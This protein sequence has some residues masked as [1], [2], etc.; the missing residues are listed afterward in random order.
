VLLSIVGLVGCGTTRSSDTKRTAT[1]QILISDAIDRAVVALK[2][3]RLSGH[4]IFFDDRYLYDAVD[5]GYLISSIRQ[6]LLANGCILKDERTDA[7]FVVE[8][9]SGA[10]GTNRHDL[11]F[12]IPSTNVPQIFPLQGLPAAIPEV[13]FAKRRDQR[14]VAKI[15]LFAYHR[16]TGRPVWQSGIALQESTLNDVWILGAGPFQHGTIR[17]GPSFAGQQIDSSSGEG[18]GIKIGSI[19]KE[20][21]FANPAALVGKLRRIPATESSTS[22]GEVKLADYSV[23]AGTPADGLANPVGSPGDPLPA[24]RHSLG[25]VSAAT[26]GSVPPGRFQPLEDCLLLPPPVITSPQSHLD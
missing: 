15:A 17:D 8:G 20:T 3:H 23:E 26:D 24:S 5:S 25:Q 6:H 11:L 10:I 19:S 16:E 21:T 9:R 14:G 22:K 7:D 4:A 18:D 13:P 12:G 2:V 1:E